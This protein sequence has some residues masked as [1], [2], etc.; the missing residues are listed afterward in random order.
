MD[1]DG[2]SDAWEDSDGDGAFNI[3][4]LMI[5][6]N[7]ANPH[8]V[9]GIRLIVSILFDASWEY[10]RLVKL[11]FALASTYIYDYTDG[12]VIISNVVLY[13]DVKVHS[14]EYNISNVYIK[15]NLD[16][17][18]Y[19]NLVIYAGP[20]TWGICKETN[21]ELN[22]AILS[23][24]SVEWFAAVIGHEIGHFAF[25]FGEEYVDRYGNYYDDC[26]ITYIGI[27]FNSLIGLLGIKTVMGL[28]YVPGNEEI[29]EREL[30]TYD[31]YRNLTELIKQ[32]DISCSWETDQWYQW[33]ENGFGL[34]YWP[35][36]A[37]GFC[38]YV[39]VFMLT[40][41]YSIY[42]TLWF[43]NNVV[44]FTSVHCKL[45]EYDPLPGPFT[46]IYYYIRYH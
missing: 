22:G 13:N 10:I 20:T 2:V 15:S 34:N 6:K 17:L 4:E 44:V 46:P 14:Y 5:G 37:Y 28:G 8:D 24:D 29:Y 31:D 27:D 36:L 38:W 41:Y 19:T 33:T 25:V 26:Y 1:G 9:L 16:A 40:N 30:S 7:P 3:Q 42:P 11:A 21:I 45:L 32:L 35:R 23:P 39:L 43:D 18:G 12:H